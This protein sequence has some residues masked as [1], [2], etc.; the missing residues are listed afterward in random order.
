MLFRSHAWILDSGA[1][2]YVTPHREWFSRYEEAMGIVTLGNSFACD[3][4]GIGD[5][6]MVLSNGMRFVIENVHHVPCLIRNLISIPQSDDLRY[7]VT[8]SQSSWKINKGN[9]LV[10]YGIKVGSLYPL[11]VSSK[12]IV[13]SDIEQP[14][15]SLWHSWLGHMSYG[16]SFSFG[17]LA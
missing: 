11:Y 4:V 14:S 1:S 15:V 2:L 16:Y 8:F 12:D 5:I 7:K 10:A 17:L 6:P 3:I 13:L 9:I